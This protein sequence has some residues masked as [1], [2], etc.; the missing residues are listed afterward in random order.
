MSS[1]LPRAVSVALFAFVTGAGSLIAQQADVIRGR[2]TSDDG[3]P[4]QNANVRAV[5]IPNNVTRSTRTDRDGRFSLTFAGGDGD[6][7]LTIAAL[8]FDQKRFEVKRIADEDILIADAKL[9][10]A[11]VVLAEVKVRGERARP[12]RNDNAPDV[13][14]TEK[15]VGAAS[16]DPSQAGD[17]AA[18]AASLPGV[19][20][21]PGADGNPDQFS[22]F[23]L[24]GDQNNST[25]NGVAFGGGDV[26][27]DAA[28]RASL[29]TSPW[30]VSRG[31]FSGGQF[32][33]RTQSGSNFS[34]RG[35]SSLATAP[36]LEWTDRAGRSAGAE[37]TSMSL[38]ASTAGPIVMD[39][40]FYNIGYQLDRRFAD[41]QNLTT[42]DPLA[43]QTAGVAIDGV[44]RD[45][46]GLE[47]ERIGCR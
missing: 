35:L 25:L 47:R 7:W 5:S 12:T 33:M 30:D 13:S 9:T 6:Y 44:T 4:V 21:I 23:G 24:G 16:V 29:S 32:A 1:V 42:A 8:G 22:V 14:G 46:S 31:G 10:R 20:L 2:I 41:L 39:R 37:F 26:P 38:G 3:Q 11:A 27:R 15:S 40:A 28:T 19:Q 17:L 34:A 36:Q 43:L 18:M 45:A